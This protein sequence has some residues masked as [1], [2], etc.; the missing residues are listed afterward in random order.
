MR[1]ASSFIVS[2][3]RYA[4][5]YSLCYFIKH[6]WETQIC[7]L[8]QTY[9]KWPRRSFPASEEG[10]YYQT[11]FDSPDD[12]TMP[13]QFLEVNSLTFPSRLN[14]HTWVSAL[15]GVG[16]CAKASFLFTSDWLPPCT[17]F[18]TAH[19]L[20]APSPRLKYE[21]QA[22]L[23]KNN[24]RGNLIAQCAVAVLSPWHHRTSLNIGVTSQRNTITFSGHNR[25]FQ[26]QIHTDV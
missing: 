19:T 10:N 21:A 1:Q 2:W 4:S 11:Q 17:C 9:E 22:L 8:A 6:S 26:P 23:S 13:P 24:Q 25:Y 16:K 7:L 5:H 15:L 18:R 12:V 14:H 20:T 3:I